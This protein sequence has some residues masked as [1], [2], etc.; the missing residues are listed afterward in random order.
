MVF[1]HLNSII[2]LNKNKLFNFIIIKFPIIRKHDDHAKNKKKKW[3]FL[4]FFFF[5]GMSTQEEGWGIQ[6]SDLR[7]MRRGPSRLSYLLGTQALLLL[8]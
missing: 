5:L 6:T 7:F 1:I 2:V 4:A 8:A 3:S